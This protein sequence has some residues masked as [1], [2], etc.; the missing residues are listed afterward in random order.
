MRGI[1]IRYRYS[2][3]EAAWQTAMNNFINAINSDAAVVGRFR[4]TATV[5]ADGIGRTHVG[6]WDTEETLKEVQS[7]EYFKRF[8]EAVQD[9]AGTSLESSRMTVA[10][11]TD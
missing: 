3:D 9:F 2:G 1:V 6:R 4:Y 11:T 7:R 8:S 5:S 10:A